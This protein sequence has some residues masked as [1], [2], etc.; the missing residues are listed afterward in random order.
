[1][2]DPEAFP[3]NL[4]IGKSELMLELARSIDKAAPADSTVLIQGESGTGK[5]LVARSIVA[6]SRRPR[7]PFVAVN[8]A[9]LPDTL[10]ESELFGHEKGAFTGADR[11]KTG[12][13][14]LAHGGTLFLDEIGELSLAAQAT[15]LRALQEREIDRLGGSRPIR[16]DIRLIAATH[17]DLQQLIAAGRFREDLYYRLKVFTLRTPAL[18]E[19]LEDLPGLV[20]F[21]VVKYARQ[22]NR[23]VRDVSPEVLSILRRHHWPGNVRELENVICRAVLA[24]E[25][26]IVQIGDLPEDFVPAHHRSASKVRN[27]YI[28]MDETARQLCRDAFAA[29]RGNYRVAA[30]MLGLHQKSMH[31]LLKKLGLDDLLDT[32]N[33]ST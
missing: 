8:C 29:A 19:R 25:S 28:T 16:I 26:D 31:R 22:A 17:R 9:G 23:H 32:I 21:F 33:G 5:E 13:F 15:L 18:R 30:K 6:K 3:H 24:G 1:M 12:K 7:G 20:Y 27:Y 11:Q 2:I 4:L 10:V 14:E